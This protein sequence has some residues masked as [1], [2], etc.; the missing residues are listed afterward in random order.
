MID[1]LN[2]SFGLN[3]G[4]TTVIGHSLGGHAAGM[5]GKRVSRGRLNTVFALD[6][7]FPLFSMDRPGE[8][9]APG[10]AN[11]V[12]VMHTNAGLLGFD[13]PIG[14]AS[15]YPNFGRTQPGCGADVSGNCA[16]SRAHEMFAES[17]N[18]GPGFWG[19][20]CRNYNDILNNNCVS[21]GG[22][23][24]MGGEPSSMGATGVFW[25]QTN[26]GNPFARG[27]IH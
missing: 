20:R 10:D 25:L 14:A 23:R 27:N 15:F 17:I 18:S 26:A 4:T 21:N 3:F 12:E 16:H 22:N 24:R 9:V 2:Q 1:W 5:T 11:Y 6:P 7:A 13:Q 19:R 8:R